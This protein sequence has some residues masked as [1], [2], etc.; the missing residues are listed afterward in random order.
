MSSLVPKSELFSFCQYCK[1]GG[2]LLPHSPSAIQQKFDEH[3]WQFK[4]FMDELREKSG[5]PSVCP[6]EAEH[7]SLEQIPKFS[8]IKDFC[9]YYVLKEFERMFKQAKNSFELLLWIPDTQK[10]W[11]EEDMEKMSQLLEDA[12]DILGPDSEYHKIFREIQV[13]YKEFVAQTDSV[14]PDADEKAEEE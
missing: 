12:A 5:D 2:C 10:E 3:K 9:V 13:Q 11:L 4:K 8:A 6:D 1:A 7:Y 14:D